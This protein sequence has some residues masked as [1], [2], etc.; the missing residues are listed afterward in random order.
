M[1]GFGGNV[2][3]QKMIN[4][5]YLVFIAM[6]ALNVSSEVLEGFQKVDR[7]LDTTI[8]GTSTRN[9]LILQELRTAYNSNPEK[10]H[11]WLQRGEQIS[12]AAEVLYQFIEQTKTDIVRKSDGNNSDLKDIKHKDD[13]E[14]A[15][16]VML[17]PIN[18]RGK[19][20]KERIDDFRTLAGRLMSDTT[21][22]AAI[23][24]MLSTQSSR[25]GTSWEASLFES[26]PTSAA[27]TMLTKIQSDIRFAE[28][29]ILS[30]LLKSVDVGDYRV[31]LITAQVIPQSQV[32]MKGDVYRAQ[33]VLSSVD[34]TLQPDVYVGGRLLPTESKGLYSTVAGATGVH[35]IQGHVEIKRGDGSMMRREFKSEYYV[36]EPMAS[37]APVLMNV[38][39]AGIDNP[40]SIAVPG[41]PSE[42]ISVT[43]SDGTIQKKGALW[44]ARPIRVGSEVEISVS[45]KMAD[46]RMQSM[47]KNKLRVRALPDPLPYIEVKDAQGNLTRFKGGRIGKSQLLGAGGLKAAIDDNVLDVNYKV[48]KFA[49]KFFDS[50]GNTIP[51]VSGGAAFSDRQLRQIRSLQRGKPFYITD[52]QAIGPDGITRRI[53][54]M[55]VIVN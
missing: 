10:A 6:M 54:P 2:N 12:K 41:I 29:E 39:K 46:G 50:M 35:P 30:D 20:L 40:I 44:I 43:M 11:E 23:R 47:A 15:S 51:E 33:I 1:S 49:T 48:V 7:S 16:F 14:A 37:V 42:N 13:L 45:A 31:N 8:G 25:Q 32:V 55:E 19:Q 9:S 18:G 38:L 53:A 24:R 5:M 4:L 36:T 17:N 22:S 52:V 28:G 3:R 26:M 27:V 34:S 21:K